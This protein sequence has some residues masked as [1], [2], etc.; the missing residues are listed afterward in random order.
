MKSSGPLGE[1]FL[2]SLSSL[3]VVANPCFLRNAIDLL[4]HLSFVCLTMSSLY[5]IVLQCTRYFIKIMK[6]GCFLSFDLSQ[7]PETEAVGFPHNL[8]KSGVLCYAEGRLMAVS[9][10]LSRRFQGK[11]EIYRYWGGNHVPSRSAV[12][13]ARVLGSRGSAPPHKSIS[14]PP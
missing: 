11:S 6:F 9:A 2:C 3:A 7:K 4:D 12:S 13:T 10:I 8:G 5:F 14:L 1:L